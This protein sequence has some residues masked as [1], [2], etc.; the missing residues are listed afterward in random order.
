M[1]TLAYRQRA[2]KEKSCGFSFLFARFVFARFCLLSERPDEGRFYYRKSGDLLQKSNRVGKNKFVLSWKRGMS[3]ASLLRGKFAY[4][5]GRL[6]G[7]VEICG[8]AVPL[9][10]RACKADSGG[11]CIGERGESAAVQR[12]Q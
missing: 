7:Q 3:H 9:F 11:C 12:L 4:E 5:D 8:Q 6:F 1:T 2:K 10:L